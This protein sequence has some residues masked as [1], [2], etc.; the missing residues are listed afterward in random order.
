M[1][2]TPLNLKFCPAELSSSFHYISG[3]DYRATSMLKRTPT[4]YSVLWSS[5]E[6]DFF[7]PHFSGWSFCLLFQNKSHNKKISY[8]YYL[9][10]E[11]FSFFLSLHCETKTWFSAGSST[12]Q[13][14]NL[15]SKE[16][17]NPCYEL[18]SSVW[19]GG[20]TSRLILAQNVSVGYQLPLSLPM[21]CAM[22]QSLRRCPCD[23]SG[24]SSN[25][26]QH[27][28]AVTVVPEE[29]VTGTHG[30]LWEN[31]SLERLSANKEE[32]ATLQQTNCE[33]CLLPQNYI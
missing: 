22:P 31:Y 30:P 23:G 7:S 24:D 3:T 11:F 26:S 33:R 32:R 17:K 19:H 27:S 9:G 12:C 13:N 18:R 6:E 1:V 10:L 29:G 20:H 21:V 4:I 5:W 28:A 14:M 16:R 2:D 25:P 15:E 8:C